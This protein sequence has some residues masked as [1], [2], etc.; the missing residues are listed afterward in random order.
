MKKGLLFVILM[1][2]IVVGCQQKSNINNPKKPYRSEEAIKNG[3]VVNLHGKISNL[4][5]FNDFMRN[6]ET[7]VKD[8]IRITMY[9]IEGDPIFYNLDYDGKEIHYMF[10]NSQDGYGGS[11]KGVKRTACSNIENRSTETEVEYRLS[12]C[13]SDVGNTFHFRVPK[14][15]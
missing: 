9:T 7:G 3:D 14:I 10:D 8:R 4:D 12:K 15:D 11:G 6:M 1:S 5:K 2:T 13:S